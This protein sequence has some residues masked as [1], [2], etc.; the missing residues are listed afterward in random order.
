M[1]RNTFERFSDF[2]IG[3]M[4]LCGL[5]LSTTARAAELL[6]LSDAVIVM[7]SGALENAERAAVD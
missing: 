5:A 3:R 4:L 1:K 6:D 7:R 2:C